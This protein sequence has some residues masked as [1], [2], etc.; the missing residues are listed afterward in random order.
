MFSFLCVA[1]ERYLM[2][3]PTK[4]V[5]IFHWSLNF[6]SHYEC[7]DVEAWLMTVLKCLELLQNRHVLPKED[8][9]VSK[10]VKSKL[11]SMSD[12]RRSSAPPPLTG[13]QK[14]PPP[15]PSFASFS[16]TSREAVA[17]FSDLPNPRSNSAQDLRRQ[18][19]I[20]SE[21]RGGYWFW[22]GNFVDLQDP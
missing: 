17:P 12:F 19:V 18:L 3:I 4:V 15:P 5:D 14:P 16:F 10:V 20:P 2:L 8:G 11:K 22:N 1:I 9:S 7:L 13:N 6:L 21:H